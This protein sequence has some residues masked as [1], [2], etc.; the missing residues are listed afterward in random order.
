[1]E[2]WKD[3]SDEFKEFTEEITK[4]WIE[5]GFNWEETK[6]WLKIGF[7]CKGSYYSTWLRDEKNILVYNWTN[8]SNYQRNDLW[9]QFLQYFNKRNLAYCD[10]CWKLIE[11]NLMFFSDRKADLDFCSQDCQHKQKESEKIEILEWQKIDKELNLDEIK[12][13]KRRNFTLELFKELNKIDFKYTNEGKK[14]FEKSYYLSVN[15]TIPTNQWELEKLEEKGFLAQNWID[16]IYPQNKIYL[17]NDDEY[18]KG[19]MRYEITHLK[20]SDLNLIGSLDLSDFIN[21]EKLDCS[22]NQLTE[23]ILSNNNKLKKVN[24]YSNLLTK[25]DLSNCNNIASLY[26][27]NNQLTEIKLDSYRIK[28]IYA[29]NNLLTKLDF[30]DTLPWKGSIIYLDISNNNFVN[31]CLKIFRTFVNLEELYIGNGQREPIDKTNYSE[32]IKSEIFNRFYGSLKH[33]QELSN[34]KKLNISNTDINEGVEYLPSSLEEINYSSQ[35][36][37]S[38]QIKFIEKDL[39]K[40]IYNNNQQ[41]IK[42]KI[43]S[44]FIPFEEFIILEKIGE[45]GYGTVYK[46]ERENWSS[47]TLALKFLNKGK[48]NKQRFYQEIGNYQVFSHDLSFVKYKTPIIQC[49]GVSLDKEGTNIIVLKYADGGDLRTYLSKNRSNINLFQK[50]KHLE[51]IIEG[52][53]SIHK[54]GLIHGDLHIGNILKEGEDVMSPSEW[55]DYEQ[56]ENYYSDEEDDSFSNLLSGLVRKD[57]DSESRLLISD[58]GETNMI[59][60]QI[61]SN[62]IFGVL[63]YIAPECLQGETPSQTNDIY[64]FSMIAYEILTGLEPY[65]DYDLSEEELIE[66]IFKNNLRPDFNNGFLIPKSLEYLENNFEGFLVPQFLEDLIKKCWNKN[67]KERSTALE[68]SQELQ[69]WIDFKEEI[70]ECNQFNHKLIEINPNIKLFS[71]PKFSHS[72]SIKTKY[73]TAIQENTGDFQSLIIE[74]NKY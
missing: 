42:K 37:I 50:I 56:E 69:K 2:N 74:E 14:N 59:E 11:K 73:F 15:R 8:L 29:H 49:E 66:E 72:K 60:H 21:L 18:N 36:K 63:P 53:F 41:Q 57:I 5:N 27:N 68:I 40:F 48:L 58:L 62:E 26:C 9:S 71:D 13:W 6:E 44:I 17:F 47:Y 20:L 39:E 19:K 64:A 51:S 46:A 67:P 22:T 3:L 55:E 54:R 70:K 7:D 65:H 32:R 23:L 16:I 61:N 33:L 43:D 38:S 4:R 31:S 34:L 45:G 12:E 52:I 24:C 30:L 25:I 1:M 10:W 35:E 28:E